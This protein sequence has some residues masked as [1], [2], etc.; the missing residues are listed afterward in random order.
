MSN[1]SNRPWRALR[2]PPP[3]T[4]SHPTT[5]V[6]RETSES[7][8]RLATTRPPPPMLTEVHYDVDLSELDVVAARPMEGRPIADAEKS[9]WESRAMLALELSKLGAFSKADADAVVAE[10]EKIGLAFTKDQ[11]HA[12]AFDGRDFTL[13]RVS[14]VA[15]ALLKLDSFLR[16]I[17]NH[18]E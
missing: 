3:F 4:L 14:P 9:T 5:T 10:A 7:G 15:R 11:S 1:P 2:T 17:A 12:V 18:G 6:S 13:S 8:V 16:R